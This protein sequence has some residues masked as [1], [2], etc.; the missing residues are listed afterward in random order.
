MSTTPCRHIEGV[1]VQLPSFLDLGTRWRW[2]VS[3]TPQPLYPKERTPGTQ[4]IGGWVGPRAVLDAVKRKIPSPRRQ[5]NPRTPIIQPV[6]QRYTDWAITALIK[7]TVHFEFIPQGQTVNQAYYVEILKLCVEKGLNFGPTIGLS[8][9]TMI[10]LT[11]HYLKHFLD[12][13]IHWWNGIPTPFPWFDSEWLLAL[14][15]NKICLKGMKISGYWRHP[16]KCDYDTES[17]S[18]TGVRPK[19]VSSSDGIVGPSAWLLKGSTSKVTPLSKLWVNRYA[20][21][22]IIP[23]LH[24]HISY[25]FQN[26]PIPHSWQ[27]HFHLTRV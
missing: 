2:V 27:L 16:K 13:K 25:M 7:A 24:N 1:E 5:S 6:A 21:S 10:Q 23:E 18:T 22:K 9:M 4:W 15:K 19:N 20:C 12:P 11:R 26:L 3:F 8:T 14:S 17:Y